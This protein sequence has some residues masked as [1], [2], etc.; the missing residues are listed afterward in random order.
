LQSPSISKLAINLFAQ[1]KPQ[2]KKTP[3]K[4]SNLSWLSDYL[5]TGQKFKPFPHF[6]C[7]SVENAVVVV[8]VV[9]VMKKRK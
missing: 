8:V 3:E 1:D 9:V 2:E 4:K 6:P 7:S 5:A